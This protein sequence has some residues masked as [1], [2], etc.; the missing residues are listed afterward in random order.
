MRRIMYNY[1]K[2]HKSK[3]KTPIAFALSMRSL[4]SHKNDIF[5]YSLV[6]QPQH[7]ENDFF[8]FLKTGKTPAQS[9]NK[10]KTQIHDLS[11]TKR[12]KVKSEG[13]PLSRPMSCISVF[14]DFSLSGC[15]GTYL[16]QAVGESWLDHLS[17]HINV[18][19]L[20]TVWN[21]THCFAHLLPISTS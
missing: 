21:E 6:C 8:F 5:F 11:A 12:A 7:S 1:Y 20:L 2:Q 3:S 19:E 9:P 13:V 10:R 16:S 4:I 18:L 17:L 15:G 14:T